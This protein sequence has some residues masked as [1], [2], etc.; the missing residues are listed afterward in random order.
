MNFTFYPALPTMYQL[1]QCLAPPKYIITNFSS[2]NI[3]SQESTGNPR[4]SSSKK[5][6]GQVMV[7]FTSFLKRTLHSFPDPDCSNIIK[8]SELNF[9]GKVKQDYKMSSVSKIQEVLEPVETDTPEVKSMKLKIKFYLKMFF[10]EQNYFH[11][12]NQEF[13]GKRSNKE[14]LWKNRKAIYD[15]IFQL[16]KTHFAKPVKEARVEAESEKIQKKVKQQE[17]DTQSDS[18]ATSPVEA[19]K[20]EEGELL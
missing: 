10:L 14:W 15:R 11:W 20:I 16:G 17:E 12:L 8:F 6:P 9:L 19:N 5:Y 2:S 1:Q 18:T 7:G 4:P 13:N 3:E